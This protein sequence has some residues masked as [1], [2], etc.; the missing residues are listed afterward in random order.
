MK[1]TAVLFM[2][3]SE[4]IKKKYMKIHTEVNIILN[5]LAEF[6]LNKNKE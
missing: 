2:F 3:S 4:S 6:V 1:F 5:K